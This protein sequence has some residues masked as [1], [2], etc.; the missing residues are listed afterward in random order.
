MAKDTID[1]VTSVLTQKE[2]DA[3]CRKYNIS[4]DLGPELPRCNDTIRNSLED[5]IGMIPNSTFCGKYN[6]SIDGRC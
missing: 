2:L 6:I 3:F 5:K 4:A 1:I